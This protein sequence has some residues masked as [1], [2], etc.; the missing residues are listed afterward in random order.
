M[1]DSSR[2]GPDDVVALVDASEQ[3]LAKVNGPDPVADLLEADGMLLQGVGEEKEP[4][5]QANG[6]RVGDALDEEV[7]EIL[8]WGQRA[9]VGRAEGRYCVAGGRSPKASWGRSSL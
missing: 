1:G 2:L 4:L 3:D 7:A 6:A 9:G 5:L 8:D